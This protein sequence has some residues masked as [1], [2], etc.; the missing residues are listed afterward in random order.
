MNLQ[1]LQVIAES[2][3]AL[4]IFFAGWQLLFHSRAMHRDLEMTYVKRYWE[5]MDERSRQF[6]LTG[7]PDNDA[8][9]DRVIARYHQLCEDELQL[10]A[11]GRVTDATWTFWA[12][13]MYMQ[14]ALPAYAA[15]LESAPPDA[16]PRLRR[17]LRE[18]PTADP[19]TW[20][21][22]KRRLRGL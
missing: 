7:T 17:I 8:G 2:I 22:A 21:W 14:N 13:A 4:A 11:T 19:L 15:G 10:R 12:E 20:R 5:L 9:D 18:G 6:V 3:T 1:L 16:Y